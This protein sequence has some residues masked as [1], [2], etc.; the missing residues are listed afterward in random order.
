[1]MAIRKILRYLKGIED[2]GFYQKKNKKFELKVYTNANWA[3]NVDERNST[4]GRAFILGKI[5]VSWTRKKRNCISQSIVESKYVATT[6]NYSKMIWI[7]KLLKIMK[8]EVT[9]PI[10]IL[11]DNK[12]S[13]NISQNFLMHIKTK[14]IAIKYHYLRQLV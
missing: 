12:S 9:K 6:I 14:H 3:R 2:Y 11:Y 7:K 8:E 10:T 4:S 5:L 13:I 1:M